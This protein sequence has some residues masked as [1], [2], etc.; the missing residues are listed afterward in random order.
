MMY[1][2]DVT[3]LALF[4]TFN[5]KLHYWHQPE[6]ETY[7]FTWLPEAWQAEDLRRAGATVVPVDSVLFVE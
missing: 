6:G 5:W 2:V 3:A 4:M 7:A 1:V